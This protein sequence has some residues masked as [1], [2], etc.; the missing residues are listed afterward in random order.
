MTEL[1][2]SQGE[3][4]RA[5]PVASQQP[6]SPVDPNASAAA[7][8]A[9]ETGASEEKAEAA[10]QPR[11]PNGRFT[12]RTEQLQSQISTLT[13][14]KHQV[15]REIEAL[16]RQ[17]AVLR[18]G[19]E[20]THRIDPNDPDAVDAARVQRGVLSVQDTLAR[21]QQEEAIRRLQE[22]RGA[23]FYAKVEAARE[24]IPDIDK[25]LQA[26]GQLPLSEYAA[27]IISESD[28]AVEIANYLGR[29]PA[30][31]Q[32]LV[33]LPPHFQGAEIGRLESMLAAQPTK[34]ISQAPAPVNTVS[35]GVGSPGVD[36]GSL[37]MADYIKAREAQSR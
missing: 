21:Q 25:S 6:D 17:R 12:K 5:I 32:R 22:T 33:N 8:A 24:R 14:Q 1:A 4:P 31:A 19:Y 28:R 11:D 13:A 29:N 2:I 26:F 7:P 18:Q 35:G 34:R 23:A 37:S 9:Q 10:E 36:L 27:D 20:A 3:E 30:V 15:R 16:E